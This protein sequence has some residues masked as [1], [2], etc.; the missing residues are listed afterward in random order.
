MY[1]YHIMTDDPGNHWQWSLCVE[2][3]VFPIFTHLLNQTNKESQI[4]MKI[5][6]QAIQEI[7]KVYYVPI[8]RM[9]PRIV[10]CDC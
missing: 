9:K 1:T 7:A 10:S 4:V 8:L 2:F 3:F 6:G 5:E